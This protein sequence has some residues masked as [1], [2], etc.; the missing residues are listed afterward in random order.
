MKNIKI[1]VA[2]LFLAGATFGGY[3]AYQ[4]YT[5]SQNDLLTQNLEAL[6]DDE[7]GEITII[8]IPIKI[9]YVT[10]CSCKNN[11]TYGYKLCEDGYMISF[12][13]RCNVNQPRANCHDNDHKCY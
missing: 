11:S 1:L 7:N 3:K 5:T 13:K 4:A 9:G 2:S 12:R 8:K 6:A 10:F